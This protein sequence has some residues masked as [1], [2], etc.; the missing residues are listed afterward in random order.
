MDLIER[1]IDEADG[2]GDGPVVVHDIEG[3]RALLCEAAAAL[4][5]A[6][7]T[8]CT[9]PPSAPVGV[10][11]R[12]MYRFQSAMR[13]MD[14]NPKLTTQQA[15]KMA[16]DDMAAIEASRDALAQKPVAPVGVDV[17][18]VIARAIGCGYSRGHQD[19]ME[20]KYTDVGYK[21]RVEYH[22][23]LADD[24]LSGDPDFAAIGLAQQPAAEA[25]PVAWGFWH[26]E[27]QRYGNFIHP[28]RSHVSHDYSK[29]GYILVPIYPPPSAP[30]GVEAAADVLH[31]LRRLALVI[32]EHGTCAPLALD[33]IGDDLER[34]LAQQ[35]AAVD[36]AMVE[37]ATM[38]LLGKS[39]DTAPG[40]DWR[41]DRAWTVNKVRKHM[42]AALTAA[43]AEQPAAV[44][45]EVKVL[46]RDEH[47]VL[48][49]RALGDAL[50]A[51]E[52]LNDEAGWSPLD[53]AQLRKA[54]QAVYEMGGE[55]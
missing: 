54:A 23:E 32:R 44:G 8:R 24:L 49:A 16:D 2:Y 11:W 13:Y 18:S 28:D 3:L 39:H 41:C 33:H 29:H 7:E 48:I 40:I 37:R 10:D 5:A 4:E 55:P 17:R 30:V 27:D 6:R 36:E 35:P 15:D 21:D 46:A 50:S 38:T 12:A 19:T 34:A 51:H 43:L 47:L 53:L 45:E 26:Q 42:R 14:N 1:L 25:Q 20:G 9:A 22:G 31:K 52:Q